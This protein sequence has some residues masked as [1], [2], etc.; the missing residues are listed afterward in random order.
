MFEAMLKHDKELL[1][2]RVLRVQRPAQAQGGLNQYF[3]AQLHHAEEIGSL[4]RHG[5]FDRHNC[6]RKTTNTTANE[7][8]LLEIRCAMCVFYL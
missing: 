1:Q 7:W 8:T 6:E 5:V 4:D 3:N 2:W